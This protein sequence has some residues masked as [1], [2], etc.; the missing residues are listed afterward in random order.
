MTTMET[1]TY[2]WVNNDGTVKRGTQTEALAAVESNEVRGVDYDPQTGLYSWEVATPST[3][4]GDR[5]EHHWYILSADEDGITM[6]CNGIEGDVQSA[7]EDA[8]QAVAEMKKFWPVWVERMSIT[9]C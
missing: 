4:H 9:F 6:H 2:E 8:I 1:G 7:L 3:E 5:P